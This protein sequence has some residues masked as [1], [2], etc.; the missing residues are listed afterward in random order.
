MIIGHREQI[1]DG[2][3]FAAG[4]ARA[5]HSVVRV[6][7]G[8]QEGS[9]VCTG[10]LLTPRLVVVPG[11]AVEAVAGSGGSEPAV[12]VQAMR[13]G[14]IART[15]GVAGAPELLGLGLL[16]SSSP[17]SAIALLRLATPLPHHQLAL[18]FES[19][20]PGDFLC[21]VHFPNARPAAAVSFG[22]LSSIEEP[23]LAYDAD[24]QPGSGGAP[25]LDRRWTVV[26]MHLLAG[27]QANRGLTRAA[28]LE[29]L[30][31]SARWPEIAR[32]HRLADVA[33]AR[34]QLLAE[35]APGEPTVDR[36]LVRAA[37][38]PSVDPHSL[39]RAKAELLRSHV[40]D[41]SAKRWVLKPEVR[42]SVLR[43]AGSPARLRKFLPLKPDVKDASR[44]VVRRILAGSPFDLAG[45]DEESLSWWI[46]ASRWFAGVVPDLPSP[47]AITRALERRR[48]RSRLVAIAGPGFRG[49]AAELAT[50][51]Q[52]FA[53]EP[54]VPLSVTGIGGVGKSALV[55]RFATD[56]PAETL[57]LWLD[58]DRP[59]VAPDDAVSVLTA[60]GAQAAVQLDGFAAPA[61]VGSDWPAAAQAL[62][63]RLAGHCCSS[64]PPL[65][66]LDSFEVA[67]YSQRHEELWP[68][69]EA[70]AQKI[71]AL[72]LIVTGRAPVKK[73]SL[74]ARP[75][76]P[77]VLGGLAPA[78]ARTWLRDKGIARDDVLDQIVELARGI[79]L[80][81]RLALRLLE[82]GG[83]VKDL[84]AKLP[85]ELVAGFLY[86]RIL[87]RVQDPQL[88]PVATAA[89]VLR[90]L[91]LDMIEPVLGGLVE[92]PPGEP[93][94]W[95]SDLGREMALVE[96][97]EV[98]RLRPEVRAATLKLLERDRSEMVHAV[99]ERAARWYAGQDPDDVEMAAELVYHRLRLGDVGGAEAAWRD[100]CGAL[101]QY[102]ADELPEKVREWLQGRL[103]EAPPAA[104]VRVW[105][106]EAVERIRS[107]RSRGLKRAVNQ[108]LVERSER[109]DESPLVFQEAFELR[110]D[111]AP[112][113]AME[114]LDAAGYPPGAVGRDRRALRALL[115]A[116]L[117]DSLAA[118]RHLSAIESESQWADRQRGHLEALAVQAARVR[119][120]TD[121]DGELAL[122][123]E[124]QGHGAGE[125]WSVTIRR[126]LS[127]I[128]VLLPPLVMK[129]SAGRVETTIQC[130]VPEDPGELQPLAR[131]V[132]AKRQETLPDEP[133]ALLQS[134]QALDDS[135]GAN[136]RSDATGGR[137]GSLAGTPER[138]R[139][140]GWR[141]W[142]IATTTQ[143]LPATCRLAQTGL[144]PG[145]PLATGIL[146]SLALFAGSFHGLV[147]LAGNLPIFELIQRSAGGELLRVPA[148]AWKHA[149]TVLAGGALDA[150]PL[151]SPEASN[152]F[153]PPDLIRQLGRKLERRSFAELADQL[154]A[155]EILIGL[156]RNQ[157][158][159][160]VATQ[161][162][163]LARMRDMED[164]CGP[165]EG[166]YAVDID[167]AN[168]GLDQEVSPEPVLM[169][170]A[171]I[172]LYRWKVETRARALAFHLLSPDPLE[173]L[174][175]ALAGETL[176]VP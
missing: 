1:F 116:G 118:E 144:P 168:Q 27:G 117:G 25:V 75:A 85:P 108:I 161:L 65:L 12:R 152:Y 86:G 78:D 105:E 175:R 169:L 72:R 35:A 100:G 15:V 41:P 19:Q 3:A 58:F 17:G 50:L 156:Y 129:L 115:A 84:P 21:L 83:D 30:Q 145:D 54:P 69:L 10:W 52:W 22:Q 122:L 70:V 127:P 59:D 46:Q 107:S 33:A 28:L 101:L 162:A 113:A 61:I 163:S 60:L 114:L 176:Q 119:L 7:F 93:A 142:R 76:M 132:E 31:Q 57:L 141:R 109:S 89:L 137:Q 2:E 103:G 13:P 155:G 96:G 39:S 80:I 26:G 125:P 18:R 63:E 79:P 55:A 48:V 6:S 159:A 95:F 24:T 121:L 172:V 171:E 82:S 140:F 14:K 16:G 131:Q 74:L 160:L 32:F 149:E 104:P 157:A 124:L 64:P 120:A 90:R 138:L 128:D 147:L 88:R 71:P 40:V 130:R 167:R 38:T 106:Q 135:A 110:A 66:V 174:V 43:A 151:P 8:P 148:A 37:L 87:D 49:R 77:V 153:N 164:Q 62:A 134:R 56:L 97:T 44:G 91:T 45:E 67:Q 165:G 98:L 92:F 94:G 133:P 20:Q 36:T 170:P 173:C 9:S 111:G 42:Q 150:P 29:A 112:G 34:L 154:R 102:A 47:A 126:F 11:Y 99:D 73:L 143:F 5:L 123:V 68:V 166:Y 136:R 139:E 23:F 146:A 53:G 81:L 158:Q 51:H 4:L